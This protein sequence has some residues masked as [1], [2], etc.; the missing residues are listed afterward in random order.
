M[1]PLPALLPFF[2]QFTSGACLCQR[3]AAANRRGWSRSLGTGSG[4]WCHAPAKINIYPFC[5]EIR[6]NTWHLPDSTE[7]WL[8]M[9]G[10]WLIFRG[11]AVGQGSGP[12]S[13]LLGQWDTSLS[14]G[15]QSHLARVTD[16]QCTHTAPSSI[17]KFSLLRCR[18]P[19]FLPTL[20]G[21]ET[22]PQEPLLP[23]PTAPRQVAATHRSCTGMDMDTEWL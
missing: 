13:S 2:S 11:E 7:Q 9:D 15:R 4:A 3:A 21:V 12:G 14:S 10:H 17:Q 1:I 16:C 18:R 20:S 5:Q 8:V 19:F 6:L 23:A 22:E